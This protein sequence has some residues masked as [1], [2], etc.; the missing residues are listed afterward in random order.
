MKKY[1]RPI[2]YLLTLGVVLAIPLTAIGN[3]RE[4]EIARDYN[5][6]LKDIK[7]GKYDWEISVSGFGGVTLPFSTDITETDPRVSTNGS[8]EDVELN[9][10]VSFGGKITVWNSALLRPRKSEET[11]TPVG[12]A[13]V[14]SELD[15][16]HF[17]LDIDEQ[18]V[19]IIGRISGGPTVDRTNVNVNVAAANLL[20]R[21]HT[22]PMPLS[23]G[24]GAIDR[25]ERPYG[26]IQPYLGL[27]GGAEIAEAKLP[28]GRKNTDISPV[29][30]LLLGAKLLV[31]RN[32]G[33]FFEYKLTHAKHKFE[34]GTQEDKATA[35]VN[36]FVFG[37]SLNFPT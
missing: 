37:V 20:L 5:E 36:H 4:E 23:I 21:F 15:F 31:H 6:F 14:G 8:F 22:W 3:D 7:Q 30:Q 29:L 9:S 10:S 32:F 2:S 28:D 18:D 19:F 1:S 34:F 13:S 25:I 33:V 24:E 11:S 26:L 12:F 27:G 16:T 17:N 35:T